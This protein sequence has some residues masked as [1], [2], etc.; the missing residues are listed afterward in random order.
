MA[1]ELEAKDRE[2]EEP[3]AFKRAHE[4]A[5]ESSDDD[6]EDEEPSLKRAKPDDTKKTVSLC[7]RDL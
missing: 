6:D 4:A 5:S 7:R 1:K 2:L 3:R